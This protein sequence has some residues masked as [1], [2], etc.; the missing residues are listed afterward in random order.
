MITKSKDNKFC[1][2]FIKRNKLE[3]F[4]KADYRI[5]FTQKSKLTIDY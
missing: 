3:N 5:K 4:I 2:I 1:N